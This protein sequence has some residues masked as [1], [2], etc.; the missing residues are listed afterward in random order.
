MRRFFL[1]LSILFILFFSCKKDSEKN[2]TE[3]AADKKITFKEQNE[4]YCIDGRN[5]AILDIKNSKL[6]YYK[7][8]GIYESFIYIKEF[9][10]IL[11]K[12]NIQF[13]EG[14]FGCCSWVDKEGEDCYA[15]TMLNEIKKRFGKKYI[16]SIELVAEKEFVINNPNFIYDVESC[17]YTKNYPNPRNIEDFWD[18]PSKKF[19]E[20]FVYPK[21]YIKCKNVDD[22][23]MEAKFILHKNGKVDSI[24]IEIDFSNA[25]NNQFKKYFEKKA[26]ESIESTK[27]IPLQKFGIKVNSKIKLTFD[28]K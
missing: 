24:N 8:Y 14:H 11:S 19:N 2:I 16:D 17:D 22:N 12:D 27:W 21:R 15:E 28:L 23:L 1:T 5:R 18:V 3:L 6:V 10:K 13:K 26:K 7:Y 9:K 4:K 20:L 25:K